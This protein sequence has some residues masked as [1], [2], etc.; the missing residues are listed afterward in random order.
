[1]LPPHST[2]I[3]IVDIGAAAYG[4][5][6]FEPL[7]AQSLCSV[8]GFEPN[9]RN[10]QQRN[11]TARPHQRYLPYAIADGRTR[12][13][14]EC[15]NPL[16]S[17]LYRP[18]TPVLEHFNEGP[19]R[20]VNECQ[21]ETRRLDDIPD[22]G[23]V[24]YMKLD[25]QGAELEAIANGSR[26]LQDTLVIHT[27]VEFVAIYEGQPLFGD[28]DVELRKQGFLLHRMDGIVGRSMRPLMANN[29]PEAPLSQLLFA[30]HVV[31]VKNFMNFG[32]LPAESLL[33]LA[34]ILHELYRSVDLAAVALRHYDRLTGSN[35]QQA[36][37]GRL[38]S[39][40]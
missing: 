22:L 34:I 19:I 28:V 15:E 7:V 36:Y 27:E 30:E 39:G 14:Y 31:Y 21:L 38:I 11:L 23:V 35:I 2:P 16:H 13:F 33:K 17:S 4:R 24:D 25:I 18:N 37:I 12:T 3:R 9:E 20:V 32:S 10:C 5:D 29:N 26:V 1:M 6:V 8:V 40:V